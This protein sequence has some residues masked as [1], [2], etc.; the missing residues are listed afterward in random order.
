MGKACYEEVVSI[1]YV[2]LSLTLAR[3]PYE[4]KYLY[5]KQPDVLQRSDEVLQK[6]HLEGWFN[7]NVWSMVIDYTFNNV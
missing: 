1:S 4:K 2:Y 6:K 5:I 3:N 7:A